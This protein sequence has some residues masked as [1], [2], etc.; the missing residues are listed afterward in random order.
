MYGQIGWS[1]L[2]D[3]IAQRPSDLFMTVLK[4]IALDDNQ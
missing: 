3:I 1:Y 4:P 2:V